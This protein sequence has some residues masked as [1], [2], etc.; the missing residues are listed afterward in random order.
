MQWTDTLEAYPA[1]QRYLI[2]A[3]I[4]IV[5]CSIFYYFKYRPANEEIAKHDRRITE[6]NAEIQSGLDM[7]DRLEEFRKEVFQLK[8]RM[9]LAEEVLGNRPNVDYLV[10]DMENIAS[11]C[12]LKVEKF[13]PL[14]EINKGFYG[15]IPI[16]LK[17]FGGYHELGYFFDKVAN[18]ARIMNI[19]DLQ[20]VGR[21]DQSN[22]TT[23]SADC[24]LTAFWYIKQ[25]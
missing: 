2:I 16:S 22:N 24:R 1:W 25:E 11:Q 15:E 20:V 8:E 18:E 10:K 14:Q 12:G 4:F 6:L 13:Q 21:S 7:K 23:I 3:L 19:T 17:L 9:R 5:A